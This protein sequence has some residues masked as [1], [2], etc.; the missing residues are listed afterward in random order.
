[1]TRGRLSYTVGS[2]NNPKHTFGRTV[3]VIEPGGAARLDHH[4]QGGGHTAFTGTVAAGALDQVW[5]GLER[6][7]FPEAPTQV[8]AV[9]AT[10]R[11]VA[12]EPPGGKKQIAHLEWQAALQFAGYKEAF[13]LLDVIVRQLSGGA[14]ARVPDD[15]TELV[16]AV[17]PAKV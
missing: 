8:M 4:A 7:K 6:G 5:A 2:E 9:G 1:M 3:L 10:V 15:G 13:P 12:V 11:V 17:K 14:V 16:T